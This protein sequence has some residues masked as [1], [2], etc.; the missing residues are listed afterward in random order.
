MDVEF[1]ALLTMT[2]PQK[3]VEIPQDVDIVKL[4]YLDK[5][6]K[7]KCKNVAIKID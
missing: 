2:N 5:N 3:D 4:I 7:P 6:Y 1:S